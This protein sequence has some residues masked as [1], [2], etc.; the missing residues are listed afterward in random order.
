MT[1]SFQ[2]AI[3]GSVYDPAG[4]PDPGQHPTLVLPQ[5]ARLGFV[6]SVWV[7]A[8]GVWQFRRLS[9]DFAEEL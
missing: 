6:V 3:Y 1:A 4:K 8:L 9:A 7:L 5:G 2:R